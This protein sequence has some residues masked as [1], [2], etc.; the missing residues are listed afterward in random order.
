MSGGS[1]DY[2]YTKVQSASFKKNT[3]ERKAFA[4]HLD[5]VAKALKDIEWVDSYDS[6]PGSENG[7]ILKCIRHDDV[8]TELVNEAKILKYQLEMALLNL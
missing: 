5:Y 6:S 7:A 2:L 8:L 1:M 4:K 3:A